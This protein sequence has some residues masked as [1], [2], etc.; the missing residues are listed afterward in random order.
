MYLRFIYQFDDAFALARNGS[1]GD[2]K[3][4]YREF[5]EAMEKFTEVV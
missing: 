5:V 1:Y 4:V 3:T 2:T